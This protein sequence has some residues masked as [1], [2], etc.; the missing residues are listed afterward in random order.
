MT[1]PSTIALDASQSAEDVLSAA[2][3]ACEVSTMTCATY[4]FVKLCCVVLCCF[5][6]CCA[7]LCC[8][9]LCCVVL[10]CVAAELS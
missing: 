4:C 3:E 7:V 6:L 1:G 8:A 5:V 10:C 2:L 9:V